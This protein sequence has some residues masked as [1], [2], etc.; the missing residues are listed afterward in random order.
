LPFAK[1][2]PLGCP[3]AISPNPKCDH[4][5]APTRSAWTI[6]GRLPPSSFSS[7]IVHCLSG[8]FFAKLLEGKRITTP[9][10]FGTVS[11]DSHRFSCLRCFRREISILRYLPV[12]RALPSQRC[13]LHRVV[14]PAAALEICARRCRTR[15]RHLKLEAPSLAFLK[16]VNVPH[17]GAFR[18]DG[19][20]AKTSLTSDNLHSH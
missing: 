15:G 19:S 13:S 11:S 9:D 18:A 2:P 1:G 10:F 8:Y 5:Q 12:S 4:R 20:L 17:G 14:F 7:G 16:P 3:A 6:Y